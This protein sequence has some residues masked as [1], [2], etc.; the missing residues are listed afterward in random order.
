LNESASNGFCPR[1][2]ISRSLILPDQREQCSNRTF[3]LY[4]SIE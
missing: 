1:P 2:A 4:V 3:C